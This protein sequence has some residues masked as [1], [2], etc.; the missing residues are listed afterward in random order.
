M[1][2]NEAKK[3]WEVTC[4]RFVAFL[5]IMGF[6]DMVMRKSHKE[7][8]DMLN[9]F[10]KMSKIIDSNPSFNT[11]V[12]ITKF[13]DSI[14]I[15]SKD[16]NENTFITFITTVKLLFAESIIRNVPLKGAFAY[17]EIS[18]N[19]SSS[20]FFGQPLIDAYLLQE[21]VYYYGVVCHN[22][23]EKYIM[24]MKNIESF[25]KLEIFHKVKTSLKSGLI[26]HL[27][28]DWYDEVNM[29]INP[30]PSI[31]VLLDEIYL[32]VSG[33]PR[34]YID[35]TLEMHKRYEEVKMTK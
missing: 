30:A 34:N 3:P 25:L 12:Y 17:G 6:K 5:D 32:E 23:I 19:K 2:N 8:Y 15:F 20:I 29:F 28:L 26:N 22:S 27:N 35:N 18:V 7:V 1:E 14:V 13:S 9:G 21:D 11:D 10:S 31:S 33:A 4:N 16:D 24:K